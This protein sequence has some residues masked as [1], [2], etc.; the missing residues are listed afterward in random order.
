M[1]ILGPTGKPIVKKWEDQDMDEKLMTLRQGIVMVLQSHDQMMKVLMSVSN[2]VESI[3]EAMEA[4]NGEESGQGRA[5]RGGE[6]EVGVGAERDSPDA[7][8]AGDTQSSDGVV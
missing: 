3:V 4:A 5:E 8:A 2:G 1:A 7:G 6:G